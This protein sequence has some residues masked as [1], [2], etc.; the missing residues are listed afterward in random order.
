MVGDVQGRRTLSQMDETPVR[1]RSGNRFWSILP[2]A[3]VEGRAEGRAMYGLVNRGVEALVVSQYGRATWEAI[4]AKAGVEPDGF[5]SMLT[6]DDA[7]TERLVGAISETL[8]LP[9][10]AVLETFGRYWPGYVEDTWIGRSIRLA[11]DDFVSVLESLDDMHERVAATMPHL[12]P[13]SFEVERLSDQR[14]RLYYFSEREGLE[15][16]VIGLL[17]GL[18]A[19]HAIEIDVGQIADLDSGSARGVFEI[20]IGAPA[21][22]TAAA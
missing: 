2:E 19:Q 16:M 15:P 9:P 14:I 4:C 1:K 12:K 21:Q 18:A 13:P 5:E 8:D 10:A 17:H 11:G 7:I 3:K 6:Y 22:K 20:Q